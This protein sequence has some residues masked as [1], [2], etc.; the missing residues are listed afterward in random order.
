M[1]DNC[2]Y[3]RRC[4][5]AGWVPLASPKTRK[6]VAESAPEL[7][8]RWGSRASNNSVS[9]ATSHKPFAHLPIRR[10]AWYNAPRV[11]HQMPREEL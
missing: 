9:P 4:C 1:A 6:K 3:A 11:A 10:L 5:S 7:R 8:Q 2:T